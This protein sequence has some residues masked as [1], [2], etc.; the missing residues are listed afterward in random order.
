MSAKSG[1][2]K[3][4]IRILEGDEKKRVEQNLLDLE[5][6]FRMMDKTKLVLTAYQVTSFCSES[7]VD[8]LRAVSSQLK[9]VASIIAHLPADSIINLSFKSTEALKEIKKAVLKNEFQ[10]ASFSI[11]LWYRDIIELLPLQQRTVTRWQVAKELK[12]RGSLLIKNPKDMKGIYQ[13]FINYSNKKLQGDNMIEEVPF[14]IKYLQ[15]IFKEVSYDGGY[16]FTPE[17]YDRFS[18][19]FGKA[20][21]RVGESI[22][23]DEREKVF[24]VILRLFRYTEELKE[25]L[26][27]DKASIS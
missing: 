5:N 2:E 16:L 23:A 25:E 27:G 1:T 24:D 12:K 7:E 4:H 20:C 13:L 15:Q 6:G 18:E 21:K 14:I 11:A 10:I 19:S 8:N 9:L 26:C 3:K 22:E 17:S